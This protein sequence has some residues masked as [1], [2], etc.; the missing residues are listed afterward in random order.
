M[1]TAILLIAAALI[2]G[3][4]PDARV[5][6]HAT[7]IAALRQDLA[8]LKNDQAQQRQNFKDLLATV[9]EY[10]GVMGTNIAKLNALVP[11]LI[12]QNAYVTSSIPE[13]IAVSKP[14]PVPLS[15][16][17]AQAKP[18]AKK[19]SNAYGV[20]DSVYQEIYREAV[21]QWPGNY[22]MQEFRIQNQVE[23]YRKLHR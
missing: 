13:L 18:S 21:R 9:I 5:A 2:C 22:E 23:A 17:N 10:N 1:K 6:Q 16:Y 14:R 8:T 7:E 12:A 15:N 3:C 19:S 11:H 20:P 4:K